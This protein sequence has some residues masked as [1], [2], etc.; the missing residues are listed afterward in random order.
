LN[1]APHYDIFANDQHSSPNC[2]LRFRDDQ[3]YYLLRIF[4]GV[5]MVRTPRRTKD[6]GSSKKS[7]NT[8]QP[9]ELEIPKYRRTVWDS[10]SPITSDLKHRN[11]DW[12]LQPSDTD[13]YVFCHN[14]LSQQN[15]IVNPDTLKI[16]CNHRLGVLW[17]LS[18]LFSTHP[19]TQGLVFCCLH[20]RSTT[21]LAAGIL[22]SRQR[23]GKVIFIM[24]SLSLHFSR[25]VSCLGCTWSGDQPTLI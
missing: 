16:Q 23:T 18:R 17:L 5:S 20:G 9:Y 4:H 25:H 1:E 10:D 15:I 21:R 3:A 12:A 19:F 2:V 13:K 24:C 6:N 22:H 11:D 8:S 14:D 7:M